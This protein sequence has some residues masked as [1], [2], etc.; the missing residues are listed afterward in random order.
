[1]VPKVIV[2][3]DV[4][5]SVGNVH[6]NISVYLKDDFEFHFY[7]WR[8][9]TVEYIISIMNDYDIILAN[10]VSLKNFLNFKSNSN[11]NL[12]KFIFIFHGYPDLIGY[13][14]NIPVVIEN[15][16]SEAMYAITSMTIS[17]L[18]P[19]EVKLYLMSNGVN[20]NEF[21]Y[22]VKNNDNVLKKIGWCGEPSVVSK[23]SNLAIDIAVKSDIL[24]SFA[25]K[26]SIDE[27]KKW[28]LDMD[29]I[30]V[31]SGPNEWNETGPLPAFEAIASGTLVIGTRVGNFNSIPGPKFDTVDEAANIINELK[32]NPKMQ[33]KIRKEQYE[34]VKTNFSYD[35]LKLQWKQVFLES[36]NNSNM[37]KISNNN[38]NNNIINI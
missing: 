11:F 34:Y 23:R 9:F 5:W 16:P 33:E 28:Y 25:V 14:C 3:G 13:E 22:K 4:G 17:S 12:K 20:L 6:K 32:N 7:E 18:F 8:H 27:L 1:M 38:N 15:F 19:K 10:Y 30:I 26:L 37:N 2:Y 35:V 24:I 29:I 36:L 31:T 21:E